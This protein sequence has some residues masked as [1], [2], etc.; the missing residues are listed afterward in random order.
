MTGFPCPVCRHEIPGRADWPDLLLCPHCRQ[1]VSVPASLLTPPAPT[2]LV[3]PG[4]PAPFPATLAD[5]RT[6]SIGPGGVPPE[7]TDFLQPAQ[8]P[9]E[10]GRLGGYRILKV[11]GS[12]G[13]GVVYLAEDAQ[14]Q[15]LVALKVLLPTLAASPSARQR[16]LR[17]AR[18][19]AGL[20]HDHVVAIYHVGED[21]GLPFLTMELLEGESLEECLQ[22]RGQLAAPEAVRV[23]R[24]VAEGLAAAHE[25]GLIH[26]DIK[27][28]NVWLEKGR[29]RVKILDFGLARAAGDTSQLTQQG[30]VLGTPAY[31]APEQARGE[32]VDPRCDLFSLGCVLYRMTTGTAPFKGNDAISTLMAVCA[33]QPPPPRERN[34]EVPPALSDLIMRLL[35]KEAGKRPASARAVAEALEGCERGEPAPHPPSPPRKRLPRWWLLVALALL[36][37]L[38]I[39]A[40]LP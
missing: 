29:G 35:E 25:R 38:L 21:R 6:L 14:L 5:A 3:A 32:S 40:A 2:P 10:V 11:L 37:G 4:G 7:L 19:A 1:P 28:A 13:M 9:D 22:R 33:E 18:A 23:G 31:M 39:L 16:F 20:R 30:A 24:A 34:P 36:L 15:R 8:A 12:G 26:R 27:P 17:E